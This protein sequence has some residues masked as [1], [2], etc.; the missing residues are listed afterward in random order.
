MRTMTLRKHPEW[1]ILD[2][3]PVR[4][5]LHFWQLRT[6]ISSFIVTLELRVNGTAFA[7]LAMFFY[8]FLILGLPLSITNFMIHVNYSIDSKLPMFCDAHIILY[9]FIFFANN[10]ILISLLGG[11]RTSW[12]GTSRSSSQC[13]TGSVSTIPQSSSPS[14]YF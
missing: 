7:I 1:M 13:M 8:N 2:L 14:S 6:T 5:W 9:M 11:A 4:H 10:A 3:W 12:C